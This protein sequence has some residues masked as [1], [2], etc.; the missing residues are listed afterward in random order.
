M[1]NQLSPYQLVE[2]PERKGHRGIG[3]MRVY[4][5]VLLVMALVLGAWYAPLLW[6]TVGVNAKPAALGNTRFYEAQSLQIDSSLLNDQET[7]ANLYEQ[8]TP[9]VVSIQVTARAS[10]IGIPGFNFP[11][12]EAPLQQGQGS[13]FIYDNEGHIV[14]NNHVVD[15]AEEVTVVFYNGFW[16]DAEVVATDPQADLAVLKVTPP[17]NFDWR[18]LP[19]AA[20]DSLR[21]GHTV[22]AMGNP[23]GL[24]GTMTTGIVSAIGRGM[25]V[26]DLGSSTYTLP[27]IIQTDAAINPGNSGGPL[28]NLAG[29]VVGVNFAIEST[30]RANSGVGFTIP[31]SIVERVV[32][33]LIQNG[34]FDYPYLGLSGRTIDANVAHALDL[35]NTLTGV[36]V[37]EVVEG[38]PSEAAGLHGS[39]Q[40]I[41]NSGAE[42]GAGGDIVTAIDD[43][44]VR[45][46][47]EL[48]GYL[49]TKTAPGQTVTLTVLR[50][51]EAITV[52]VV[53]GSRPSR[54][55]LQREAS[56]PVNP[57][58]A[59][60]IAVEATSDLLTGNITDRVVT[61][62]ERDGR[63]VWVVELSTS[64]Q[65]ATVII[66][67]LTGEVLEAAVE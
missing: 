63:D 38:G 13:G 16:A 8:I 59:L 29:E 57:R 24:D 12:D 3:G 50:N 66:D 55:P 53:L 19:L 17:N 46:F 18:P 60:E 20:P 32:P 27:E 34:K 1:S 65:T 25:P 4:V 11:Q 15:G 28:I 41:S 37:A 6:S 14:T 30:V 62:E 54:A 44:P 31:A 64:D 51:N 48:V 40:S 52:D 56:G 42:L 49:V 21:V 35:P 36:Y 5:I 26:G 23:F 39:R 33:A 43:L 67:R 7:L 22:I 58:E 61:Q 45:R 2:E 47:E 10:S 9:S